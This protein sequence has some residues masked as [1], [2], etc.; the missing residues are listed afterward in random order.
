MSRRC[1]LAVSDA[2]LASLRRVSRMRCSD[3]VPQT[4]AG[5]TMTSSARSLFEG[6]F[7]NLSASVASF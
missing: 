1:S 7:L 5:M 2:A 4:Y 6:S 3:L